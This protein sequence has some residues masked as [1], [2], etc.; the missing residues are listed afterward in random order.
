MEK[1]KI[2]ESD[3]LYE[4]KSIRPMS[5]HVMQVVFAG[6]IPIAW[7]D[8]TIYTEDGTKAT[9]LTGYE[10][11]YKQDGQTV[12]LSN[13]GSVYTPP[14]PPEPAEPPEPY[15]P[16]LEE[17]R[18]GKKAEVSAA[19]EQIIYAGINV[20]LSDGTTEHYSLTEHDQLN[21]FGKLSQISVGAAQ[22]EYHADGQSCRYYTAIDMQAIIQAAMRHVSYHTTYC[23]ALNMWIAG[24]Q[25][26]EEVQEIFYGADVPRQYRSEVLNAY[27][28]QIATEIGVGEYGTPIAE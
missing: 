17:V 9:T 8:I 13:D 3:M 28:V 5:S 26:T 11:V 1:I 20:T 16:T 21:L 6:S 10:T 19:C 27:L 7:G 22:L 15:V 12:E 23:N 24:C 4:I 14:A 2:G 25:T 18:V